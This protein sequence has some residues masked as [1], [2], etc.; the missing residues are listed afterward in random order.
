MKKILLI[1]LFPLIF[2]AGCT[3]APVSP[4][5]L[6][7]Q[8]V[9]IVVAPQNFNDQELSG[10]KEALEKSGARIEVAGTVTGSARGMYGTEARTDLLI[11]NANPDD[12]S[13]IVIIGG[14]G[15]KQYLWGDKNLQQLAKQFQYRNKVVA[16]I[17]LSPAVL[18]EAGLLN[19]K[20]ATVFPDSEAVQILRSNGAIYTDKSLALSGKIVTAREPASTAEFAAAIIAL[21]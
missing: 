8:K 10:T 13:A 15:S 9:L 2:I 18:A 12:Y 4:K 5:N 11:S 1:M 21:L 17:C 3:Q 7:G 6:E 19:G 20:E 16:A 14:S